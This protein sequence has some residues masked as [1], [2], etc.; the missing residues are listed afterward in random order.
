MRAAAFTELTGPDGV[1]VVDQ[2]T[3]D[4]GRDEALVDVDA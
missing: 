4:P 1:D 3:P 2:P